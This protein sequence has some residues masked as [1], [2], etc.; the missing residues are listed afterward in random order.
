MLKSSSPSDGHLIGT[1]KR[2]IKE[3]I[4]F[5]SVEIFNIL[6]LLIYQEDHLAYKDVLLD[7]DK[8]R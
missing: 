1:I 2:I 8:L 5:E 7:Y 3:A 6:R 4:H